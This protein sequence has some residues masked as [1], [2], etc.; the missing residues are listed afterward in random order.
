V[1]PLPPG[2]NG[3]KPVASAPLRGPAVASSGGGSSGGNGG[4]EPGVAIGPAVPAPPPDKPV[5]PR[6]LRPVRLGTDGRSIIFVEC[7]H[8]EVT[9]YP[10]RETI[11][12]EKLN[13]SLA[14]NPLFKAVQQ[15]A[16]SRQ[17]MIPG[18][19]VEVRFLVHR[20][21][22]ETFHLAYPRLEGLK[23]QTFRYTLQPWDDLS[24][25]VA[26]Y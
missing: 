22:E 4:G 9:I 13:R 19:T 11:P 6:V 20:D 15:Q 3:G 17:R 2:D 10:G 7:K 5:R 21:A 23:L 24:R 12:V 26:E 14:Y 18:V 16:Q 8:G 1:P 25:I